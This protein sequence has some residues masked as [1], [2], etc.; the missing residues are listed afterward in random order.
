MIYHCRVI[1]ND[2]L[3]FVEGLHSHE[4]EFVPEKE[5]E[6]QRHLILPDGTSCFYWALIDDTDKEAISSLIS[7]PSLFG[8]FSEWKSTVTYDPNR[9]PPCFLAPDG[10]IYRSSDYQEVF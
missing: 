9:Q 8:R 4:V 1:T 5:G 3:V 6:H 7:F 2:G 10:K